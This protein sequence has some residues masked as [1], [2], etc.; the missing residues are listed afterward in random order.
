LRIVRLAFA[1]FLVAVICGCAT[2]RQVAQRQGHGKRQVFAAPFEQTWRAAIDAAYANRL[3]ILTTNLNREGGFISAQRGLNLTS[4]GQNVGIWVTPA[5]PA[6][7]FVEIVS[8][9]KLPLGWPKNWESSVLLSVSAEL[10]QTPV[11]RL[12][13]QSNQ[14]QNFQSSA[15]APPESAGAS[16]NFADRVTATSPS[17]PGKSK[18]ALELEK[19]REELRAYQVLRAEE[20]RLETDAARRQRLQSELDY[21]NTELT[22]VEGRLSRVKE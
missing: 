8:R 14:N 5:S 17:M 12:A 7:T 15:T 2:S 11:Q 3:T 4:V 21:L 19:R 16:G 10:G 1:S 22:S 6:E 13:S 9:Q 20:L 18:S